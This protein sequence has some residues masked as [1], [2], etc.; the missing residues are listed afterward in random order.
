MRVF[1]YDR[2]SQL[3]DEFGLDVIVTHTKHSGS[4]I[5]DY[6][7][8]IY[9]GDPSFPLLNHPWED[10]YQ[11]SAT[12]VGLPKDQGKEAFIIGW[13]DEANDIPAMDVWIQDRR[14]WGVEMLVTGESE[15]GGF[16][17]GPLEAT[18]DALRDRL[19]DESVIGVEMR[20]FPV[21][22]Y[23][24]LKA[25]LP[26]ATFKDAEPC[27]QKLRMIKTPEEI[28]RLRKAA[29][30]LDTAMGTF[31]ES[32][33][34]DMRDT[35]LVKVLKLATLEAGGEFLT[36][37]MAVG[38]KGAHNIRATGEKVERGKIVRVDLVISCERYLGDFSRVRVFGEPSPQ[39]RAVHKVILN[40]NEA[41]RSMIEPG[42]KCSDIYNCGIEVMRK[43]KLA[44]LN[45]FLGHSIGCELIHEYPF[46]APRDETV[47][48]PGMVIA[49]EP[50][51]RQKGVGSVNIE[52]MVLVTQDGSE[53]L[54]EYSRG[55][56]PIL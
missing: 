24:K 9:Y 44:P 49:V 31:Y 23:R 6:W 10:C 35:D 14:Y 46:I 47:L 29:M 5:A 28:R 7:Y 38:P 43:G 55:L 27:L 3:M 48:T 42:I 56:D 2:A 40:A 53:V 50:A 18:A 12:L 1:D 52:D 15:K 26:K 51:L 13:T 30:I 22:F 33:R 17:H 25:L 11:W 45:A 4:Y 41:M 39:T 19:L 20:L 21:P 8:D 54:T 16:Y 36:C 34:E 32:V 37:H